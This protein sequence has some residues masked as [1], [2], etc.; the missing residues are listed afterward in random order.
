MGCKVRDPV[1]KNKTPDSNLSSTDFSEGLATA[2]QKRKAPPKAWPS[3]PSQLRA[4]CRLLCGTSWNW[5]IPLCDVLELSDSIPARRTVLTC[6][7]CIRPPTHSPLI[8]LLAHSFSRG[9]LCSHRDRC[10]RGR[11]PPRGHRLGSGLSCWPC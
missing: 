9:F 5:D 2:D 6:C 3:P 10:T 8:Y 7:Q 4:G 11:Q 1:S